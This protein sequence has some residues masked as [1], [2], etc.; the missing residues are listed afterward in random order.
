MEEPV[1]VKAALIGLGS[2]GTTFLS[3]IQQKE[4]LISERYG[5]VFR[6]HLL[7]DSS[8]VSYLEHDHYDLSEVLDLKKNGGKVSR[9]QSSQFVLTFIHYVIIETV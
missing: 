4:K 2:V 8:G 5:L 1:V 7:A 6:F 9:Y 3:I